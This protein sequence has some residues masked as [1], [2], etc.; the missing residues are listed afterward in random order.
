MKTFDLLE[1]SAFLR[2]HPETLRRL[3]AAGEVPC[4]KPSSKHWLFIDE[5][6]AEWLR[7]RYSEKARAVEPRGTT[8][9][10]TADP[11]AGTGGCAS[12]HQTAK[13]YDALL[14]RRTRKTPRSTKH[15]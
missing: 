3:A 11:I 4:A 15:N 6:L 8:T 7:S 13:K 10:S 5:D 2:M 12:P 1:A 14:E 9:C